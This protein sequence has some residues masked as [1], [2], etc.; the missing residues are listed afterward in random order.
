MVVVGVGCPSGGWSRLADEAPHGDDRVGQVEEGVDHAL[1]PFVAAL[2]PVEAVGQALV[3][4]TCQRWVA[5]IVSGSRIRPW[6]LYRG[7][8]CGL[9][10]IDEPTQDRSTSDPAINR[11]GN[12]R[13]TVC[14]VCVPRTPSPSLSCTFP[15]ADLDITVPTRTSMIAYCGPQTRLP[16]ARSRTGLASAARPLRA[17]KDA[18][19]LTLRHE[20]AVAEG[21]PGG[22]VEVTVMTVRCRGNS[23]KSRAWPT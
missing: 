14:G 20:I 7:S 21:A 10:L 1:A 8:G 23:G 4:S 6:C 16:D 18:E 12:R 13:C 19:I 3:R 17:A 22:P 15:E 11:L 5:W 2:Q 9:V